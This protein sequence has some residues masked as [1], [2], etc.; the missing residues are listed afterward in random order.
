MPGRE[1]FADRKRFVD[2]TVAVTGGSAGIGLGIP[3]VLLKKARAYLLLAAVRPNWIEFRLWC[4]EIEWRRSQNSS[5]NDCLA[6]RLSNRHVLADLSK[7]YQARL[8]RGVYL[9]RVADVPAFCQLIY[10]VCHRG[11]C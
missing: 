8:V 4:H 7:L 5:V 11:P 1:V 10:S 9:L 3:N 6:F 2:R